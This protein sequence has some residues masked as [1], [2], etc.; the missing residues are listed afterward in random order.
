MTRTLLAALLLTAAASPVMASEI[1]PRLKELVTVTSEVVLIG[2]LVEDAGAVANIA[3]F[4]APNPGETGA[5]NV[6]RVEAALRPHRIANLDTG[7]LSEIV[8]TRLG[9]A[10]TAATIENLLV[11]AIARQN[12]MGEV[13]N[14][15]LTTDRP[16]RTLHVEA[17][18]TGELA[19]ARL[20]VEPRT[21]RFDAMLE[22]PG[23]PRRAPLRITGTISETVETAV[24]TKALARGDTVKASDVAI[25]RKRKSEFLTGVIL[26]E[27]AIG[28]AAKRALRVGE[29]LRTNDLMK[30]ETVKRNETVTIVYEVPGIVLTVRGKALEAGAV[31]DVINVTNLQS[32]RTVQAT[33]EAPGRVAVSARE[34]VRTAALPSVAPAPEPL[35]EPVT[36]AA[37]AP[38]APPAPP[39]PAATVPPPASAPA[40][41]MAPAPATLTALATAEA[42]A[43][44]PTP[45]FTAPAA[46]PD[47]TTQ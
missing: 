6:A 31:G 39:A 21:G 46:Q 23:A 40:A 33:V 10:F 29:V 44:S 24:I 5:V 19:I 30:P 18:A 41:A 26:P 22:L 47:T 13:K 1:V 11:Q 42:L 8:V 32:N 15:T 17:S 3:V 34:P 12:G 20:Q 38:V 7:G 9:R 45:L 28:L 16:L 36:P 14:L 37:S 27:Q 2:D 4:R 43:F 35:R 25:E